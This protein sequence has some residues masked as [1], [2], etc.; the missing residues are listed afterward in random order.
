MFGD[1]VVLLE[2][3]LDARSWNCADGE[4]V[5]DTMLVEGDLTGYSLFLEGGPNTN[6]LKVLSV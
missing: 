3:A 4:P 6:M 2:E 1:K 5:S